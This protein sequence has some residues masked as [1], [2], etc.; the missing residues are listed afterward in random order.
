MSSKAHDVYKYG[1]VGVG[2]SSTFTYELDAG[3]EHPY[4]FRW[5]IGWGTQSQINQGGQ[6]D[7]LEVYIKQ[8]VGK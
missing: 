4:G 8:Q 1:G 3:F 7:Y 6:P 2:M 5:F